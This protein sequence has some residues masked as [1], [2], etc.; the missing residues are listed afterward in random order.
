MKIKPK[1]IL[2][3]IILVII[4]FLFMEVIDGISDIYREYQNER[5]KTFLYE[6]E[7]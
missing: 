5:V 7:K 1:E 6:K 3:T 2:L 4:Y